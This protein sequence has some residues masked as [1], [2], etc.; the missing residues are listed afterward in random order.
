[1]VILAMALVYF[2]Y[3]LKKVSE[4]LPPVVA[5]IQEVTAEFPP[6]LERVDEITQLVPKIVE[7]VANIRIQVDSIQADLPN[8]LVEAAAYR[9]SIPAILTEVE[10]VRSAIPPILELME[11]LQAQIP[12]ILAE[13]E[14]V[15]GEVPGIVEQ[16]E[17]IQ[18]QI[19]AI[20]AEV[21]AVRIS[22]PDYIED[23]SALAGEIKTAGKEAAEGAAQ[24]FFTGILKVPVNI[25]SEFSSNTFEGVRI[26]DELREAFKDGFA[27]L[28]ANP[29]LGD[30]VEWSEG[31]SNLSGVFEITRL[32]GGA[33]ECVVRIE[34][35]SFRN[36]KELDVLQFE[37]TEQSDGTWDTQRR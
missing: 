16:I 11:N 12:D 13:M 4:G 15:R 24:G 27:R 19:P 5:G 26:T 17:G 1:M 35:R 10:N 31:G 8:I 14:A 7:E 32:R 23:A 21:E 37:A 3:T 2:G 28:L 18:T 34:A 25:V 22:I 30:T 20:L 29:E 9:E 33:G 6:I 36:S